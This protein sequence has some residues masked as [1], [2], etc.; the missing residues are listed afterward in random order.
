[1]QFNQSKYLVFKLVYF[2]TIV[3]SIVC[4][5]PLI[6]KV[7]AQNPVEATP[8]GPTFTANTATTSPGTLE[9]EMGTAFNEDF[10]SLPI[11]IKYTP[12]FQSILLRNTEFSI[13]FDSISNALIGNKRVTKFGD[14]LVV[15]RQIFQKKSFSFALAPKAAFFV[16]ANSG[17]RLGMIGLAAY[18]FG[19]NSVVAN[20]TWTSATRP[21][22]TNS[23]QKYD[24]AVDVARTLGRSAISKRFDIFTGV[25]CEKSPK[26]QS[27]VSLG[28][29]LSFR[30]RSN[31]VLDPSVRSF[32]CKSLILKSR[33]RPDNGG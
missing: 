3:L 2:T 12:E 29:G 32:F 33:L 4:F 19:Q 23:A 14:R 27:A 16:R 8:Q 31:L 7:F 28:Q 25:L 5:Q 15:R 18:S 20:L 24:I 13:S 10:A 6:T 21:S 30:L 26:Q 9:L 22:P 11:S 1:M 17:A